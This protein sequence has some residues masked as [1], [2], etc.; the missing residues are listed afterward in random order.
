MAQ[1]QRS[2]K[3]V[4][5]KLRLK[6]GTRA[7]VL[8]PP[9]GYEQLLADAPTDIAVDAPLSGQFDWIQYFAHT[10]AELDQ[11]GEALKQALAPTT[12]LWISYPKGRA[13]PTDLNRDILAR[14][15]SGIGLRPVTQVAIDD[16]WSALRFKAF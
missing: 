14:H 4:L 7:I 10:R 3:P 6:P 8:H 1:A 5:E 2:Q 16:V 12:V 9:A 15:L 11:D 13:E